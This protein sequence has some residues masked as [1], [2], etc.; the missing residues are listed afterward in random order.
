[1]IRVAVH[2]VGSHRSWLFYEFRQ[3]LLIN[4]LF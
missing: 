2:V 4:L 1:M 3:L